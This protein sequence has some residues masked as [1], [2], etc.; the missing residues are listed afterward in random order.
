M[1]WTV[2]GSLFYKKKCLVCVINDFQYIKTCF[3][4]FLLKINK[5]N[6]VFFQGTN[7]L[8]FLKKNAYNYDERTY[9]LNYFDQ[10][11][12]NKITLLSLYLYI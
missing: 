3:V 10:N 1:L 11:T 12:L 9:I 5:S 4:S 7:K 2:L 6:L 8:V